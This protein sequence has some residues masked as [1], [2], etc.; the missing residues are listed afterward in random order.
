MGV[1]TQDLGSVH[2]A[3]EQAEQPVVPF[4]V[5]LPFSE[6]RALLTVVDALIVNGAV[7]AAL[8]LWARVDGSAFELAFV[9]P[10]WFWFPL[11][12]ALWWLLAH[13]GDLYDVPV[14][15][16][17]LEATQRIGWVG[18]GLLIVYLAV[19]FFLPRNVLPR[20]FFLFFMGIA[21]TGVL[22][23]RWAYATIFTLPSFRRRVLIAGAGWAGRTIAQALARHSNADY[24]VVG[25]V[26]DAPQ[27]QGAR[28]AGLPVMGSSRDLL[29][30]VQAQRVD[31]VVVA[32]THR[33]R[34]GLFQAL[35]DCRAAGVHVIRMPA[36]YEQLT[37]RVPVEHV[38]RGW[39]IEAVNDLPTLHRPAQWVKR[40]L[41]VAL[42]LVGALIFLFL[43]PFLALAITLD[44]PGPIFYRQLRLGL[45]GQPYRIFKLRTMVP[46]AEEDGQARWAAA[47]D[48]R[49]TRTGRFLR[50]MRLDELPQV[51]NVLRGEMS[52]VGPRPERPEFI[53]EL[54]ER[55]PFYRTRLCVKPGLTGWAQIHYGYGNSVEDALI[56]LQHDL[57]Y[58][59]HW[60]PWLDLYVVLKTVGVV[61]RCG[62]T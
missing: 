52:I 29:A 14:A 1:K 20:W 40:L 45:G 62:G 36:L 22:T 9:R 18:L 61:L 28:V 27:K 37:R 55:I 58:I 42:G 51:F 26:D 7:L 38:E 30:V 34:G 57:Y 16:Q 46:H 24:H 15:G 31:E 13:L 48:E 39:V 59:R 17:R 33:M 60:S 5:T 53:A 41:D 49:I 47:D 54:Q 56:K 2:N 8:Y 21:L 32:V 44:C 3:R 43:L 35:M 19:Y 11:L 4:R 10:R 6:R 23:W 50:K 25:F 12:T